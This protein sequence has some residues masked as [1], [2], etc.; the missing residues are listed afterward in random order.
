MKGRKDP[1]GLRGATRDYRI[2]YAVVIGLTLGALWAYLRP[3]GM[4]TSSTFG[5]DRLDGSSSKDGAILSLESKVAMLEREVKRLKV[6]NTEL[7]QLNLKNALL[8]QEAAAAKKQLKAVS[9]PVKVGPPGTVKSMRTNQEVHPDESTNPKLSALLKKVAVNGELIVGIS[10][11]NVRDMVQIWFESI[12]RVGVTNYLVVALDDEIAS[13]CQD[14]DVPVYRR[15]ATISKS[16]AGTGA[17]HAISGLK[18]HLLR[19]FLV[20]GY[21]ILLSDVDIVYLQNPFNHLHR[22]CDVESM[23]DGF[24]N[25]TAYGYDDVMTDPSMGWSRYA[26][27][28][29]IWVFNSGLFYIRPTV[30]SIE[31]LDRVTA[32]LAKEKAW[33]QAVFNEELFNPS[34]PGY[35]G[36]HASRRVLDF[37]L[38]MNSKVLFKILR[39]EKDF[40]EYKPVTIHV[41]YHPDKYDRMLAIVEYYV[42][43][44]TK[45]LQRFP[46]GSER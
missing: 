26:H 20:L 33:D 3:H 8:E 34:H 39:K 35:E 16:Q 1:L 12:K 5:Y 7:A 27:T 19:E 22:D 38:F 44:N 14:H 4:S 28:M 6:E 36:L 23:S 18:F 25:T 11:N 37:Y 9:P 15:D 24:D 32:K 17:N 30:P 41:N 42:K 21:S 10:N 29:R 2:V 31:L 13:F 43:G 45:A 46:D 40:A